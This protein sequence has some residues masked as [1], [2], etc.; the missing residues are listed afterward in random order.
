MALPNACAVHAGVSSWTG[1]AMVVWKLNPLR[2][3]CINLQKWAVCSRHN[4]C[5]LIPI[6]SHIQYIHVSSH[7]KIE[8][9]HRKQALVDPS[10]SPLMKGST[11]I[12]NIQN[13]QSEP[14][15]YLG[16][17]ACTRLLLNTLGMRFVHTQGMGGCLCVHV[18]GSV[19]L[20]NYQLSMVKIHYGDK[21]SGNYRTNR[22]MQFS[23]YT[24]TVSLTLLVNIMAYVISM[25]CSGTSK[26]TP[27]VVACKEGGS[28][29]L[30]VHQ[31]V[32][33]KIHA[34]SQIV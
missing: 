3:S 12:R 8:P 17:G 9:C 16:Y 26:V 27:H 29:L 14:I 15:S 25:A 13:T 18:E 24:A 20:D 28:A 11:G 22:L 6:T 19:W 31:W 23:P 1:T 34:Y 21:R 7:W 30:I 10:L 4:L 33:L 2:L 32:E 5:L